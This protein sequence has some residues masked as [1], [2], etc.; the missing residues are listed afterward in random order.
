[1]SEKKK[2]RKDKDYKRVSVGGWMGTLVLSAIPAVNLI[3][4]IIWAFS[5]KKPSRKT[6]AIACLILTLI[7]AAI[8]AA[9]ISLFGQQIL[10]WARQIDPQLF[11]K[12][13]GLAE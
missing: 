7:C 3:L 6:F 12:G 2:S 9:V 10:D 8:I 4:W 5:A 13:L 1:M 11:S